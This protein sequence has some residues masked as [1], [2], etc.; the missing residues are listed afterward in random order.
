MRHNSIF[1][2]ARQSI[3]LLYSF[4]LCFTILTSNKAEAQDKQPFKRTVRANSLSIGLIGAPGWPIGISYSKFVSPRTS[5]T[6]GAGVFSSGAGVNVFLTNPASKRFNL[7]TGIFG[8]VN[9]DG[10]PMIYL[11]I[12]ASYIGKK[13]MEYKID[14]GI[15]SSDNVS[16]QGNGSNPSPWF[17]AGIGYRFGEDIT[18]LLSEE[19]LQV[20]NFISI[21]VSTGDPIFGATYE[22][23]ISPY[24][25]VE[26][27]LGVIGASVGARYYLPSLRPGRLSLQIGLVESYGNYVFVEGFKTHIPVGVSMISKGNYRFG[28][29]AGPAVENDTYD[30]LP[31]FAFKFGKGF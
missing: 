25:G 29:E 19:K 4:L 22:R 10:F 30:I 8:S 9:Y 13:N 21:L 5:L 2:K 15:L 20:K 31:S 28:F 6:L 26:A 17:G 1:F 12:G 18:T 3:V 14:V 16:L 23:L 27:G 7:Y 11:P 24:L